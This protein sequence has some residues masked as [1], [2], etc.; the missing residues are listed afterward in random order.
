MFVS[1]TYTYLYEYLDIPCC[2]VLCCAFRLAVPLLAVLP[3]KS[4]GEVLWGRVDTDLF[5]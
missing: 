4:K 5:A 3:S 1:Q 2:D